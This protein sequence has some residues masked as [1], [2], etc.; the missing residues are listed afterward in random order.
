M[1]EYQYY[2]FQTIDQPLTAEQKAYLHTLS[3]RAQVTSSSAIYTYSYSDFPADPLKVLKENFDAFLYVANWGS[4]QLVF[5]FPK[6]ALNQAELKAYWAFDEMSLES[7]GDYQIL[8]IGFFPEEAT[9]EWIEGEGLLSALIPLRNE[10]MA[11]DL[12]ALYLV[13]LQAAINYE[14]S[15]FYDEEDIDEE[16]IDDEEFEELSEGGDPELIEPPLPAGLQQL[17]PSLRTLIEFLEIDPDLVSAAAQAS[18]P[19]VAKNEPFEEWVTKLPIHERNAFLV[20]LARRDPRVQIDL[21]TRLH[22]VGQGVGAVIATSQSRRRFSDIK[23]AA[24]EVRKHRQQKE[25]EAAERKRLA[26][27]D[28]LAK[29]ENEAWREVGEQLAK[30]TGASYDAAVALLAQLR[31]L[32]VHRNQGAAFDERLGEV[33]GPF[34]RSQP[35]QERMRRQHLI[36]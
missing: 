23:A 26:E 9:G 34:L 15:L 2:E 19:W 20:R 24:G 8:N 16:E 10:I 6:N 18:P 32:A 12:R 13:W 36:D 31:D 29:R 27:L 11:G 21:I 30:R 25:R 1:S 17:T 4:K 3:R 35:L 22:E 28:K 5:R 7:A 33:A 14:A